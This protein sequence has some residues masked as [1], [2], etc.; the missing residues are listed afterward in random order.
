MSSVTATLRRARKEDDPAIRPEGA[1]RPGRA[2]PTYQ[3][4]SKK[5][6]EVTCRPVT[7]DKTPQT[8]EVGT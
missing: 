5:L 8:Q 6:I 4:C 7:R 3:G 1:R 2:T